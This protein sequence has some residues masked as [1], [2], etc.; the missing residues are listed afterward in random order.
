M[1][2][3]RDLLDPEIKSVPLA[4]AVGFFIT[5]HQEAQGSMSLPKVTELEGVQPR[6]MLGNF[7]FQLAFWKLPEDWE[8]LQVAS[9]GSHFFLLTLY[10]AD[11][12][13]VNQKPDSC[14]NIASFFQVDSCQPKGGPIISE[15][16]FGLI[17]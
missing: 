14:A 9:L 8:G 5:E 10:L 6:F 12:P 2:S 16:P 4:L 1:P 3:C 17:C 7:G 13:A 15:S 11:L